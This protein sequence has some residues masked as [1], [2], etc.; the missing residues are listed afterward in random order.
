MVARTVIVIHSV[1][2]VPVTVWMRDEGVICVTR[3]IVIATGC[4][5]DRSSPIGL[6]VHTVLHHFGVAV[7]MPIR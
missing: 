3:N 2:V 7:T 6:R 1:V 4:D 5:G